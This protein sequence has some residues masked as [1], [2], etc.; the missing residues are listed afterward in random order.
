MPSTQQDAREL[1]RSL[2]LVIFAISFGI[3]F[4][5]VFG[6]PVGSPLFTGF[7]RA[8][9]AGDLVYSVV[10]ALPVLGAVMQVF[11]SYYLE[12]T[13]RRRYL[14]LASGFVQ[15]LSWVP[16]AVLPLMMGV[17]LHEACIWLVTVFVTLSSVASSVNTIA[18]NSWMGDLV[19]QDIIGRFFS[20]RTIVSTVTGGIAGLAVGAFVD[21]VNTLTGFAIVFFIGSLFGVVDIATFFWVKHPEFH[22]EEKAPS[23]RT[24]IVEPFRNGYYLKMTL[25][26]TLFNFGVNVSAPFFNVYMI[27]ELKMSYFVITLSNQIATAIT[28]VLFVHF[29]GVLADRY[30][31][32][33]VVLLGAIG[34]ITLPFCWMFTSSSHYNVIYVINL[35]SGV[36][37]SAY[38]LAVFNQSVWMAPVKNRSAY[39]A[40]FTLLTNV[41]GVALAYVCGGLFMQYLGP[42][43]DGLCIPFVYG[44]PFNRYQ[45][46]FLLSS[47]IRL[48][49]LV[50]IFPMVREEGAASVRRMVA[51]ERELFRVRLGLPPRLRR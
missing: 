42:V 35:F 10:M 44:R 30:G 41:V 22:R 9:G 16:V 8:L 14:F 38:N 46:V 33:P 17:S 19:P 5:T 15:R 1:H 49:V 11:G 48:V 27:E 7:M 29:W 13:G 32:R 28:T 31:N 12:K 25:F 40:C 39:I 50:S 20:K 21:H 4:F 43:I 24:V 36:C 34:I 51:G 6:T 18:F 3:V 23:L 2:N 26:V 47:L 45:A 37:W